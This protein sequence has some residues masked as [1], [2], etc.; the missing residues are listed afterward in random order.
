ML[1]WQSPSLYCF[2]EAHNTVLAIQP[3]PCPTGFC[4]FCSSVIT[5]K[6]R[7][8]AWL[9]VLPSQLHPPED[10]GDVPLRQA[11]DAALH[12]CS[13]PTATLSCPPDSCLFPPA[14]ALSP[15]NPCCGHCCHL[16]ALA[17]PA[18]L[19]AEQVPCERSLCSWDAVLTPG[20]QRAWLVALQ[21]CSLSLQCR[22]QNQALALLKYSRPLLHGPLAQGSSGN[23]AQE[24]VIFLC[25]LLLLFLLT[26]SSACCLHRFFT[27]TLTA[28]S[29]LCFWSTCCQTRSL[30]LL[31][32][33][34]LVSL[35]WD[36]KEQLG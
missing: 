20:T 28:T 7:Q 3:D 11:L 26:S 35:R 23:R 31:D 21:L 2:P 22:K 24:P 8:L 30:S 9:C 25:S 33:S 29:S 27:A 1:P 10:Q 15:P 6:C 34:C 32:H 4:H 5:T 12:L 13:S 17:V 36:W 19:C 14:M 18:V 16:L